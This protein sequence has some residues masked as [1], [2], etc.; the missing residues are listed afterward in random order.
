MRE[1]EDEGTFVAIGGLSG[2]RFHHALASLK[3]ER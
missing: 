1:G 2:L 3:S